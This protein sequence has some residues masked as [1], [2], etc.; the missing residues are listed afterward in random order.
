MLMIISVDKVVSQT[1]GNGRQK[2]VARFSCDFCGSYFDRQIG[3]NQVDSLKIK[4]HYCERSCLY[5][6]QKDRFSQSAKNLVKKET[7]KFNKVVEIYCIFNE[8]NG[9]HYVGQSV[10]A[11]RRFASHI[12]SAI[13]KKDNHLFAKAIRK[14]GADSFTLSVVTTCN[15]LIAAQAERYWIDYFQ[16]NDP[17]FGY[18]ST[19]GGE[20]N[21][22]FYVNDEVKQ[23]ISQKLKG[24]PKLSH[25]GENNPFFGKKH[26]CESL[27]KMSESHKRHKPTPE[28]I[29]KIR[30]SCIGMKRSKESV[31]KSAAS[32]RG[33]KRSEAARLKMSLVHRKR[34][35]ASHPDAASKTCQFCKAEFFPKQPLT[36]G[37]IKSHQQKRFC[38][39]ECARLGRRI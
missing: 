20:N 28:T 14:H 15:S 34:L 24:H 6:K 36:P 35:D 31:E 32:R 2:T 13:K 39:R 29:E 27:Q 30:S 26:S 23:K 19:S 18:N 10:C 8:K 12:Y 3:P 1:K 37:N 17:K 7:N 22:G 11:K 16:S 38:S 9:K 4:F 25:K 21:P 33:Q 5:K